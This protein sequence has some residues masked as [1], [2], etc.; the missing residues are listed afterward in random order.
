M[1]NNQVKDSQWTRLV[2]HHST[3]WVGTRTWY[4]AEG[5]ILD[6]VKAQR[7]LEANKANDRVTQINRFFHDDRLAHTEQWEL[8]R[9]EADG[10]FFPPIPGMRSY[11]G[12]DG[13]ALWAPK[14]EPGKPFKFELFFYLE[15]TTSPDRKR[16]SVMVMYDKD[17]RLDRMWQVK[18][19]D[20]RFRTPFWSEEVG[21]T[22]IEDDEFSFEWLAIEDLI[23]SSSAYA[24]IIDASDLQG[25][26]AGLVTLT[27]PVAY[28]LPDGCSIV[29]PSLI[30]EGNFD[31]F[32]RLDCSKASKAIL[33]RASWKPAFEYPLLTVYKAC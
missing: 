8:E 12:P 1:Q 33:L 31:A 11:F 6:H 27:T 3:V 26:P 28:Q 2:D 23:E 16:M 32:A 13:S 22:K 25:C 7:I 4:D 20:Y 18:E 30:T 24:G 29:V 17:G 21:I 14:F 10:T 15:G 5:F 19:C 9:T